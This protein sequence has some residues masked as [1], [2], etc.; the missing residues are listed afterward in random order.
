MPNSR[1]YVPSGEQLFQRHNADSDVRER[2]WMA[3]AADQEYQGKS[4]METRSA[5]CGTRCR[6]AAEAYTQDADLWQV[7]TEP[8][9]PYLDGET[10][11]LSISL[12]TTGALLCD[13]HYR[14]G[15]P[16]TGD[17]GAGR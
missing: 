13:G 5:S 3:P 4:K 16:A 8:I 1:R 10:L 7:R 15:P 11:L 12:C 2:A 17:H 9:Q 6:C 14:H